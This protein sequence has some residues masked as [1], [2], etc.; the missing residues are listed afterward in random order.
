MHFLF[1]I[2]QQMFPLLN[3][4][5]KLYTYIRIPQNILQKS[6]V[7]QLIRSLVEPVVLIIC[8]SN[9]IVSNSQINRP[10]KNK[11]VDF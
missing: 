1:L 6:D 5:E 11:Q 8:F 2:V 10:V 7:H 3:L 4:T 9:I